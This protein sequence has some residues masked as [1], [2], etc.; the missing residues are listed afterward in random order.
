MEIRKYS[1]GDIYNLI[2]G[3]R[4]RPLLSDEEYYN[5][6]W[7]KYEDMKKV[8]E[9]NEDLLNKLQL[10]CGH[11]ASIKAFLYAQSVKEAQ[12]LLL[13]AYMD[14]KSSIAFY[15]ESSENK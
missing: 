13:E 1:Y 10:L 4:G 14:L 11:L 15:Q 12:D 3:N 8:V 2:G 6:Q 5:P 7:C 9:E